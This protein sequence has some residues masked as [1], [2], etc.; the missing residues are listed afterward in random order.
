MR[1]QSINYQIMSEKQGE[2][3]FPDYESLIQDASCA[4]EAEYIRSVRTQQ[5]KWAAHG[6]KTGFA[7][8]M[9]YVQRQSCGHYEIFQTPCNE[10]RPLQEALQVAQ[11]HQSKRCTKCVC[12]WNT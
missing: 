11:M 7:Y 10:F 1:K 6:F 4:E 12:G 2:N 9:V 3:Y 5:E 8:N